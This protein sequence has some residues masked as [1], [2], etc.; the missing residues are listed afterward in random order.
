MTIPNFPLLKGHKTT[1]VVT[2]HYVNTS[3]YMKPSTF[4]LLTWLI[5]QSGVDN[6]V[7]YSVE[8]LERYRL[9]VRYA[10]EEYGAGG[11][12][13]SRTTLRNISLNAIR[14]AFKT[15]ADT[16]YLW[17]TENKK[18]FLISPLLTYRAEYV[19]KH[20]YR[21]LMVRYEGNRVKLLGGESG[22]IESFLRWTSDWWM[23]LINK[24]VKEKKV[25]KSRNL[26]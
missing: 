22:D 21:R 25:V 7:E 4:S 9:S 5:Y 2:K 16:G 15:L 24:R 6:S 18:V 17:P 1:R 11:E 8:L 20:E 23:K 19:R 14:T 3:L 10:G 26:E 12:D 13:N